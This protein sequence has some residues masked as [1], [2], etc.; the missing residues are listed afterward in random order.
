MMPPPFSVATLAA[1]LL[2]AASIAHAAPCDR[3]RDIRRPNTTIVAVSFVDSGAF[4]PPPSVRAP[5]SEIFTSYK[6]LAAFCR[7]EIVARPTSDSRIGIEVWLPVSGWNGR[8]LGVGNG[9]YGGSIGYPRLGEALQSGFAASSTDTGHRGTSSDATWARGHPEKQTDFDYRA[10]H[11]TAEISKMLIRAM[12]G[13]NPQ[14]SYFSACSNGG[15][16]ALMEAERYPKDYDGVLAGAPATLFGFKTFVNGNLR[17]FQK[18]GGKVLIYHGGEDAPEESMRYYSTVNGRLSETVTRTFLQLYVV[19]GMGH[20]GN[21]GVPND[22][23]QW[24]RP[25]DDRHH[26]LFKALQHWVENGV[27]PDSVIASQF[28][29]DGRPESGLVKTRTLRPY[30]SRTP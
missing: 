20:C 7:V 25:T 11:E 6:T 18:R 10:I 30:R 3:L 19:P 5:S 26:S 16:Q 28:I 24:I 15:R 1:F 2:S 4:M 12:F 8:Y 14:F 13:S 17:A 23:G 22:I 9:S 21:G 29:V 27:A